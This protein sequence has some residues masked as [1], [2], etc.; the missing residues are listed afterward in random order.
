L[1]YEAHIE[2]RKANEPGYALKCKERQARR[3]AR[4]QTSSDR[5]LDAQEVEDLIR[6]QPSAPAVEV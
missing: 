2:W 6:P 5:L 3:S 4:H 1:E